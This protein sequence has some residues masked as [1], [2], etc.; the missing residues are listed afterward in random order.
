VVKTLSSDPVLPCPGLQAFEARIACHARFMDINPEISPPGVAGTK[1]ALRPKTRSR[2]QVD[3]KSLRRRAG[4]Y[5]LRLCRLHPPG[6]R[7][8]KTNTGAADSDA[9]VPTGK[10]QW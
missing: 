8:L 10:T 1:V 4:K 6:L 3:Q 2:R 9:T 5:L 7:P